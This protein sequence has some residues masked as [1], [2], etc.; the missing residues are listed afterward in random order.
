LLCAVADRLRACVREVDTVARLGGD[1]FAI[2]QSCVQSSEDAEHLACRIVDCVGEPYELNG[3]RAIIGCSVGVSLAPGDGTSGEALLKNADV[4]LYRA[5]TDG[6]GTWRFFEPA[7]DAS[8][9][10]RRA[11]EL[12][13]REA[14]EKDEFE[15][16]YQP[17]Y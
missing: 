4:A 16:F 7:M 10:R 2:I 13:L 12:D 14:M 17:L 11:L 5:K 3:H 9:Q 6:R 1:E 8:L 15:L